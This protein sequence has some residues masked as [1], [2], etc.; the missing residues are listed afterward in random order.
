M[1]KALF[2]LTATRSALA[3]WPFVRQRHRALGQIG[4][5]AFGAFDVAFPAACELELDRS[6]LP[7]GE[8]MDFG[9]E[10]GCWPCMPCPPCGAGGCGI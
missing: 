6:A 10:A 8:G 1:A 2:G 9:G 5:Q 7:V 4:D 3:S